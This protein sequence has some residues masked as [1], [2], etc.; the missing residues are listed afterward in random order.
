MTSESPEPLSQSPSR[1]TTPST[2]S[3]VGRA[4][5]GVVL[6]VAR[7]WLALF[8]I[9]WAIYVLLPFAAPTFL[10]LGWTA[11]A[12]AIYSIYSFT[13]HQIP[14]HSYFLFGET[15]TPGEE[16]LI[17]AGMPDTPNLFIQR[18]FVGAEGI[19]YKVALC[20]RDVAIYASVVVA[21]LVFGLVRRRV[22]RLPFVLFLLLLLPIAIDGGTQLVGLRESNWLLRTITGAIFGV[23][24]VWIA[25][26]YI[27]D[28]MQDVI[29]TESARRSA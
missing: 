3:A 2:L 12:Q 8:T 19:G 7:H 27:D 21:G 24:C 20:Q 29:R 26:P 1:P 4:A 22:R 6:F 14:D 10:R 23:A 17:V 15:M 11:P 13:C 16:A 28:A 18:A 25:Y 5:D 9:A